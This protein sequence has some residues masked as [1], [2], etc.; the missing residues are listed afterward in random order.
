MFSV[1]IVFVNNVNHPLLRTS[2]MVCVLT[3]KIALIFKNRRSFV[4]CV[5]LTSSELVRTMV[6]TQT[7]TY[8]PCHGS[9]SSNRRSTFPSKILGI[10]PISLW[11]TTNKGHTNDA[12]WRSCFADQGNAASSVGE[13]RF[14]CQEQISFMKCTGEFWWTNID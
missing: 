1:F 8:R 14:G 4:W 13:L 3:F 6:L 2:K 5:K 11:G 10:H 7:I 12:S 9:K